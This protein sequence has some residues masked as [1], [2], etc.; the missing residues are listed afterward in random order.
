M[1]QLERSRREV[2]EEL[3][4][5]ALRPLPPRPHEYASWA[6]PRVR[7]DYHVEFEPFQ[8]EGAASASSTW[9]RLCVFRP[10]RTPVTTAATALL[11]PEEEK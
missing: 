7:A 5:P 4:R 1:R 9:E 10:C 8:G 2:F 11:D 3:E 6:R